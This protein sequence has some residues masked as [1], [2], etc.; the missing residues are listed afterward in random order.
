ML[1]PLHE[2]HRQFLALVE[3]VRPELHRYCARMTGSVVDA[4]DIVQDTLT[5]AYYELSQLRELPA[6][7]TWLFRI[8]HHRAIDHLRRRGR[9]EL[10]DDLPDVAAEVTEASEV[11]AQHEAVQIAVSRFVELTPVQ[12]ACVALKDVLGYSLEECSEA[13]ELSIP[14]VKSAL[15]RGRAR[16]RSLGDQAPPH[17]ASPVVARYAALFNARDWDGVRALLVDDVKL[18]VVEREHRAGKALVGTYFT[19]YES[20]GVEQAGVG[21]HF[22]TLESRAGVAGRSRGA[23]RV[24]VAAGCA[25]ELCGR[26]RGAGR[27]GRQHPRLPPPA[28]LRDRRALRMNQRRGSPVSTSFTWPLPTRYA[29]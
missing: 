24:S 26:A 22:P 7:R 3:G 12:R 4:E 23:L 15:H 1:E 9:V 17:T 2:A 16:L 8:A 20:A 14:A 5:R 18:E 10:V 27:A 19:N 25:A 28:L 21:V 6:M 13:L 11:M 29:L